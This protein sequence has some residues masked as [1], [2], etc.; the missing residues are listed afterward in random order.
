MSWAKRPGILGIFLLLALPQLVL[1]SKARDG[2][3][4]CRNLLPCI[5]SSR[6]KTFGRANVHRRKLV[7][8]EKVSHGPIDAKDRNYDGQNHNSNN[9]ER[10]QPPESIPTSKPGNNQKDPNPKPEK[11]DNHGYVLKHVRLIESGD[12][13]RE[14]SHPEQKQRVSSKHPEKRQRPGMF[15][16]PL[17]DHR[18]LPDSLSQPSPY[19]QQTIRKLGICKKLLLTAPGRARRLAYRGQKKPARNS[20]PAFQLVNLFA[21]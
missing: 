15:V 2:L 13:P 7:S 4:K 19:V 20:T 14:S 8:P 17:C 9:R 1:R 6:H 16:D 10:T 18:F 5:N 3:M 11:P 21:Q 12:E